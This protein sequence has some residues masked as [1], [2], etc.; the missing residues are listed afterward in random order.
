MDVR[1]LSIVSSRAARWYCRGRCATGHRQLL[2]ADPPKEE[3]VPFRAIGEPK[4]EAVA[5]LAPVP[6]FPIATAVDELPVK[7]LKPPPGCEVEV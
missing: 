3:E 6:S 7:K 2:S 4:A 1:A 5:K